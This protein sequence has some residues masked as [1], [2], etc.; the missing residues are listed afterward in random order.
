VKRAAW[1]EHANF[2]VFSQHIFWVILLFSGLF[3][4]F[5]PFCIIFVGLERVALKT[6]GEICSTLIRPESYYL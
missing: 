6:G 2:E 4:S 5:L 3:S 1:L